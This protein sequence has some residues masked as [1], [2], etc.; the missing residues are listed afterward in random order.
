MQLTSPHALRVAL[1]A[2][3]FAAFG[4]RAAAT[5]GFSNHPTPGYQDHVTEQLNKTLVTLFSNAMLSHTDIDKL[6]LFFARDLI[7]HDPAIADGRD[8][9]I[10][11]ISAQRALTPARTLTIKHIL[12]DRDLVFV[13]SQLSPTPANEKSGRNRY[14][15]YRLD[16]GVIV[17]HWAVSAGVAAQTAS[18]NSQFSNLYSY[19]GTEPVVTEV[20]EEANRLLVSELSN[21]V[22]DQRRFGLLNR[23]WSTGYLQH[24]PYVENGRTALAEVIEYI[25]PEGSN[26]RIVRSMSD[27]DLSVVCSQNTDPGV[28]ATN[29]FTGAAVC[30]LYR[31]A[32]FELVEH[33]DVAQGVPATTAN[34]HS[35][36]SD[37]YRRR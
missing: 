36:F 29:E 2:A 11:W 22:F 5:E 9:M 26:Y 31:V 35:M 37:L 30:D 12:A 13:H 1:A 15:F 14:D 3:L 32:D 34:G 17:E 21:E 28:D 27:G 10:Q 7:Q 8:A 25:A 24:N 16:R 18:G 4:N 19:P 23:F 20:R 6:R 33:W